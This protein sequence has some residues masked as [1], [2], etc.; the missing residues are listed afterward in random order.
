MS[1]Y[2]TVDDPKLVDDA[3]RV[4]SGHG[5]KA[6]E[7]DDELRN[8]EM[9]KDHQKSLDA[10]KKRQGSSANDV[11]PDDPRLFG[12]CKKKLGDIRVQ[13]ILASSYGAKEEVEKNMKKNGYE[14]VRIFVSRGHVFSVFET[15][16]GSLVIIRDWK[17]VVSL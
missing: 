9:L 1:H 7:L 2:Y 11:A 17:D 13:T 8:K 3:L 6:L 15:T 10:K 5:K 14:P 16:Q 12:P 4:L